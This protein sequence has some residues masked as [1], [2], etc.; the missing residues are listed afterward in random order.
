MNFELIPITHAAAPTV[1]HF[2]QLDLKD[3]VYLFV[4]LAFFGAGVLSIIFIFFGGF[5]FILSGG[6]E[7]KV[8]TAIHTI[9]YAIIG[10]LISLLSIAIVPL[11]GKFFGVNFN[12]LDPKLLSEKYTQIYNMFMDDDEEENFEQSKTNP[13][14][15]ESNPEIPLEELIK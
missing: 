2:A 5:S 11:I 10:L 14:S 1:T 6:D 3:V 7:S 12:F 15:T 4:A 13:K 9:R 8:K